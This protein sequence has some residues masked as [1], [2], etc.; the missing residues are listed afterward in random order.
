MVNGQALAVAGY[1]QPLVFEGGERPVYGYTTQFAVTGSITPRPL[2]LAGVTAADKA[3]DGSRNAAL[4]G[5]VLGN[6]VAGE[7]LGLGDVDIVEGQ[8]V[9]VHH[10]SGHRSLPVSGRRAATGAECPASPF[11]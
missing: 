5:G 8:L 11:A 6:L 1:V 3:Y 9:E 7:T 4:G 10:G 2:S